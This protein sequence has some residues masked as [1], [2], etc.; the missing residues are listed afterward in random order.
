MATVQQ[1]ADTT[2]QILS[3]VDEIKV[4]IEGVVPAA[5]APIELAEVFARLVEK[6]LAGWSAA[7]NVPITA[8]SVLALLPND[9]PLSPPTI[10]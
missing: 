5:T 6:A 4:V 10:Q 1:V 9:T 8:E 2:D 3:I 7:A